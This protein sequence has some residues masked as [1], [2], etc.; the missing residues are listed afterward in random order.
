M[1]RPAELRP[2]QFRFVEP[3]FWHT[4]YK[5]GPPGTVLSL[6]GPPSG[7]DIRPGPLAQ[8]A[9]AVLTAISSSACILGCG[10]TPAWSTINVMIRLLQS[11]NSWGERK[12]G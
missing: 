3:M 2:L 10:G 6:R 11:I 1:H 7:D 4:W 5:H 12:R 9:E 8:S